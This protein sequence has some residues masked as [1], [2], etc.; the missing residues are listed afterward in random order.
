MFY[1]PLG[2]EVQLSEFTQEFTYLAPSEL[3]SIEGSVSK[4]ILCCERVWVL[5][6][7]DVIVAFTVMVVLYSYTQMYSII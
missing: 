3:I 1:A 6:M 2:G 5:S 7:F 4:I